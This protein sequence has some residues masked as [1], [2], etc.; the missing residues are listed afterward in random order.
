MQNVIEFPYSHAAVTQKMRIV[1]TSFLFLAAAFFLWW[2]DKSSLFEPAMN[3]HTSEQ[4][5]AVNLFFA[6]IFS[7]LGFLG[8]FRIWKNARD[9]QQSVIVSGESVRA[10]HQGVLDSEVEISFDEVTRLKKLSVDGVWEFNLYSR[11]KNI[12]VPKASLGIP[13]DFDRLISCVQERVATCE[14][15]VVE[16]INPPEI[17]P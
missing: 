1:V 2:G 16:R 5:L 8:L 10:P 17:S 13:E 4:R 11:D 14:I 3:D 7:G 6:F 15:E 12:R 9:H